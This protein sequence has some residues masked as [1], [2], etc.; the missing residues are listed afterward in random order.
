MD[1]RA[2]VVQLDQG[3]VT[4]PPGECYL[5]GASWVGRRGRPTFAV[6]IG[7]FPSEADCLTA[8]T[9][10]LT[11]IH[12]LRKLTHL[13]KTDRIHAEIRV[14]EPSDL[15]EMAALVRQHRANQAGGAEG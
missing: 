1:D 12:G 3:S 6:G 4:S 13:A 5:S 8:M 9:T 7:V 2:T 14:I 11:E 10:A 15:E